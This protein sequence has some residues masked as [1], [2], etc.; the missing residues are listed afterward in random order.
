MA[1]R[2]SGE[3]RVVLGEDQEQ[4][5]AD[6]VERKRP[7]LPCPDDLAC[8]RSPGG[9]CGPPGPARTGPPR[10]GLPDRAP[11]PRRGGPSQRRARRA[12]HRA[13][14]RRGDGPRYGCRGRCRRSGCR[15]RAAGI[16]PRRGR[17]AGASSGPASS[18]GAGRERTTSS[19][20]V[21][22]GFPPS[23]R[24]PRAGCPSDALEVP[25]GDGIA[26]RSPGRRPERGG[27]RRQIVASTSDSVIP[28]WV[29]A[30]T[31]P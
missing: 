8:R 22:H 4:G 6:R 29:T 14:R 12:A 1:A 18:A 27:R 17:R 26:G 25:S 30:R 16:A 15:G 24:V 31:C 20:S 28:W 7:P 10:T 11:R 3:R 9:G 2:R 23:P 5:V 19:R 21:G 13:T